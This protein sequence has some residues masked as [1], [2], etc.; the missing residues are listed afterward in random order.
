M[1]FLRSP[2]G[3]ILPPLLIAGLFYWE[4]VARP[5]AGGED[6]GG[7]PA[8][9]SLKPEEARDL[10][11]TSHTLIQ[12]GRDEEALEP[13]LKLH[14]AF[15]ENHIYIE[16]L[17]EIYHRLGRYDEEAQFWEKYLDHA[18]HPLDG[19]PQIGQA[20]WKQGEE[21]EAI[22]AFERCLALDQESTSSIFYL[23]H[24]LEM[25]QEFEPADD[26]YKRGLSLSPHNV[27]LRVGLAR[28]QFRQGQL[29][30]A[31]ETIAEVIARSPHNVD[32]LLVLGL[33]SMREG[34]LRRARK[35]LE[36]G[37]KLSEGY[38]DF[39]IALG[40]LA[41]KEN[42]IPEAIR[43]YNRVLELK[44]GN[45]EIRARRNALRPVGR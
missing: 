41:E 23:A 19:C 26:M 24:A 31:K 11:E 14:E 17:A 1:K 40:R 9:A 43:Q 18:P 30:Q 33:V 6:I 15:P 8:S 42:N 7:V 10:A 32:A 29:S 27:D 3:R 12:E 20:Y 2:L 25:S 45:E 4:L 22:S 37:V 39:H 44:P 34:D 35:Y 5:R 28:V 13:S 36:K 38:S 16:Q 21:K